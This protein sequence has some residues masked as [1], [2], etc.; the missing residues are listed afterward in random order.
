MSF[1]QSCRH[2]GQ[3]IGQVFVE[4]EILLRSEG[5]VH[6]LRLTRG[7][8]IGLA[9]ALVGASL[10]VT[11]STAGLVAHAGK[12]IQSGAPTTVTSSEPSSLSNGTGVSQ[13][14][15]SLSSSHGH[16]GQS[17]DSA[18]TIQ[19]TR[20]LGV[21]DL[22]P[23]IASGHTANSKLRRP[24]TRPGP[25]G[26]RA[27]ALATGPSERDLAMD[28][29]D[30]SQDF[31]RG[32]RLVQATEK[33]ELELAMLHE[34]LVNSSGDLEQIRRERDFL[35]ARITGLERRL[36]EMGRTQE[37]VLDRLTEQITYSIETF[38]QVLSM[39]GVKLSELLVAPDLEPLALAQGG[40]FIPGDFLSEDVPDRSFQSA[41][42]LLQFQLDRF[43]GLQDVIRRVPLTAPL[44]QYRMSSGFGRRIDPINGS[45]S[46]H[47]GVDLDAPSGTPVLSTG[48][49]RV[50]FAGWR[51]RF[52]RVVEID[53]GQG[54]KSRYA[55]LRKILVKLDQDVTH[56][57][58]IGLLGTSG[59][60]TGPHLHYEV[61]V[62]GRPY[63]PVGFI[64]AG[65]HLFKDG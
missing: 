61:W 28:S 23:V 40:P 18:P 13:E 38:E 17:Q 2:F 50:V 39:T 47:Y 51:G 60:S 65:K 22:R 27:P 55:H 42:A 57:Q 59:R 32:Q 5:R 14:S 44:D 58:K 35:R 33:L 31:E 26:S 45:T 8:Q 36:T 41:A 3:W 46:A 11:A 56:R 54:V 15:I 48:S 62:N 52:G 1:G 49:G 25:R 6:Y 20:G 9:V 7:W 63:N 64:E 53:H 37:A 10:Y 24:G 43:Q 21:D 16:R 29:A 4:R 19:A 34:A 30:S 12:W